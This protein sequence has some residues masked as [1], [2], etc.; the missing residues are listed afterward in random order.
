MKSLGRQGAQLVGN[1]ATR[2]L[3]LLS[4]VF[5][6]SQLAFDPTH[7][8]YH[9]LY[10]YLRYLA[11]LLLLRPGLTEEGVPIAFYI[12]PAIIRTLGILIPPVALSLILAMATARVVFVRGWRRFARG[13]ERFGSVAYS[14]PVFAV[15]MILFQ[16]ASETRL[17]PIGSTT[18]VDFSSLT[19]LGK[20]ID[21]IYH[22]LLPWL[23]LS[24]FPALVLL[25]ESLLTLDELDAAEHVAVARAH[26]FGQAALYR[27]HIRRPLLGALLH[28][29]ASNLPLILSY[30]VIVEHVFHYNGLGFYMVQ[31]YIAFHG[32]GSSGL[33]VSQGALVF[34]GVMTI[35][36][37]TLIR[38]GALAA[39]PGSRHGAQSISRPTLMVVMASG[40][41]VIIGLVF[42]VGSGA[43]ST[44]LLLSVFGACAALLI[45]MIVVSR[46]R[47]A[48]EPLTPVHSFTGSGVETKID[49]DDRG[50][51][52]I[53]TVG[54]RKHLPV[55][56]AFAVIAV[57]IHVIPWTIL[58]QESIPAIL[59]IR[60]SAREHPE[61]VWMFFTREARLGAALAPILLAV[62]SGAATGVMAGIGSGYFRV[63][64]IE[65]TVDTVSV[66]PSVLLLILFSGLTSVTGLPLFFTLCVA[67][68]IQFFVWSQH[69]AS[70]LYRMDFVE[71]GRSIGERG[72]ELVRRHVVRNVL[73]GAGSRFVRLYVDMIVLAANLSYLL[74]TPYRR[75]AEETA[76]SWIDTFI[77]ATTWDWGSALAS[78]RTYFVRQI[79]LPAMWPAVFLV[80]TVVFLRV[81]ARRLEMLES[82]T[83]G[84]AARTSAGG[85]GVS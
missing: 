38:F 26:G 60:P 15:A 9:V 40:C 8:P 31:P 24:L 5:V 85:G 35:I 69:R 6:V 21:L 39:F 41:A 18:S 2:L 36:L 13:V 4:T 16:F 1:A 55:L 45:G 72:A 79:Y 19:W 71:Y 37:Q 47:R 70:E 49:H 3:L 73:R 83:T 32:F 22:L 7:H 44:S 54:G 78:S 67:A 75:T 57:A 58:N 77:H 42:S 61:L 52:R 63:N 23:T 14:V 12:R 51:A 74:V 27:S 28:S 65:R 46:S 10:R 33:I 84:S 68:F 17:F 53:R 29:L 34:L 11:D 66:F 25:R 20:S 48:A 62:F 59:M 56:I 80:G 81:V 76:P 82:E 64:L 30:S 43:A 50:R